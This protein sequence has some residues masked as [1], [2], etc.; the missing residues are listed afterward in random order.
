[1]LERDEVERAEE[2]LDAGALADLR[3]ARGA[4]IGVPEDADLARQKIEIE[5]E[6]ACAAAVVSATK[7]N[8]LRTKSPAVGGDETAAV[9]RAL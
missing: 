5:P 2:M 9:A 6:R 8:R 7:T 3:E 1:V 4:V